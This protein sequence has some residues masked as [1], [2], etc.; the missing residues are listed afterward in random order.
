MYTLSLEQIE[1]ILDKGEF[2]KNKYAE[3]LTVFCYTAEDIICAY[4]YK[5][6]EILEKI[7][8]EELCKEVYEELKYPLSDSIVSK[9]SEELYDKYYDVIY[10]YIDED[11]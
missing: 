4:D 1:E 11:F 2:D 9:I 8:Y 3:N 5:L 10:D 7:S 6:E